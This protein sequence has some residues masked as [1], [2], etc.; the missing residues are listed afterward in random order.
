MIL[1]RNSVLFKQ[2]WYNIFQVY[3]TN[4]T[5]CDNIFVW[6]VSI[7]SNNYTHK[8]NTDTFK[9][10]FVLKYT[11]FLHWKIAN[12]YLEKCILWIIIIQWKLFKWFLHRI[13][14]LYLIHNS[15]DWHHKLMSSAWKKN[16]RQKISIYIRIKFLD[17]KG[18]LFC[19]QKVEIIW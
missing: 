2:Y 15:L 14:H 17:L 7:H 16:C 9:W 11:H 13:Y 18:L 4:R 10:M 12:K 6:C 5:L 3:A 1:F 19:V 8:I